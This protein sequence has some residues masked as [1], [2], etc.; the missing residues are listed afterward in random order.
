MLERTARL[1]A[2][3]RR[4]AGLPLTLHLGINTGSVVAGGFGA[5][6]VKSYSV[7]GDTVNTAQRLQSLA[8]AGEV[9]VGPTTY[10]LA[11]H[12]F[13]FEPL[14]DLALKGKSGKHPVHRLIGPLDAPR[15][16]RVARLA[17]QPRTARPVDGRNFRRA[18]DPLPPIV[19]GTKTADHADRRG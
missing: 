6:N 18:R 2:R 15:E 13:G 7:T 14:G 1:D 4:R 17:R 19:E 8:A 3:W 5:G 10:R 11:R 16:A 9:L 12:A